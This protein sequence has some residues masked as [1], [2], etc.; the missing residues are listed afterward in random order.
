MS[1]KE[2]PG[3]TLSLISQAISITGA[4]FQALALMFRTEM[5]EVSNLQPLCPE[6]QLCFA[7]APDAARMDWFSF[8]KG[9]YQIEKLWSVS[10]FS[11]MQVFHRIRLTWTVPIGLDITM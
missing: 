7:K 1:E 8:T 5:L 11:L 3:S 9:Y 6:D 10:F 4:T 2:A